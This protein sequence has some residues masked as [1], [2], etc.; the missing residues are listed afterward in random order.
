MRRGLTGASADAQRWTHGVDQESIA[1]KKTL[2]LI[3]LLSKYNFII[4]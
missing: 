2:P 1:K 3:L 4:E